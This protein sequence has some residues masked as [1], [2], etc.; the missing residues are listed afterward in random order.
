MP[1]H[2]RQIWRQIWL[3]FR[4]YHIVGGRGTSKSSS[5]ASFMQVMRAETY[6]SRKHLS[7]SASKFRGGKTIMEDAADFMLGRLRDQR[8]AGPYARRL[9]RHAAAVKRE[10]DRWLMPLTTSSW[11]GTV[12][13]GNHESARGLRANW[14]VLDEADNWER[15]VVD[16]YFAP[17][18]A[19]EGSFEETAAESG[20]NV[21]L[22]TG[23]VTYSHKDWAKA[24]DSVEMR[25]QMRYEA[26]MALK[27]GDFETYDRLMNNSDLGLRNLSVGY[28]RWDYT[29]LIIP[30][31]FKHWEVYY[32]AIKRGSR[33]IEVNPKW[34][35]KWDHRDQC[36]YIFTYPFDKESIESGLD[37]GIAD[38]DTWAAENRC[39]IIRANGNVYPPH[40]LEGATETELLED[41]VAAERGWDLEKYGSHKPPLL[42]RCS[43]PCVLGVDPARTSDFASFVVIRIGELGDPNVPYNPLTGEG[44]TPW[45]NVIWAEHHRGMTIRDMCRKI[46]ELKERYNLIVSTP[47]P[48]LA[49]A[50]GIDARGAA[51]GTT[52]RDELASPAPDVDANG[53]PITGWTPPQL[54]YDPTDP[55]YRHLAM[56]TD[57]WPGL[58]LLWTSDSLNTEW[59]SYSK[60]QI[61]QGRLYI[62]RW[63][64]RNDRVD[65]GL[66]LNAGYLG[67]QALKEQLMRVQAEPTRYAMKFSIPGSSKSLRTKD[68]L[69]NAFLYA[70]SA[71]R[72][73]LAL[74]TQ[75]QRAKP[76]AA[77]V[78]VR[79]QRYKLF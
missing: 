13:T 30:L 37:D 14:L 15:A 38:F 54:I 49:Y 60:A 8:P 3:H 52:I 62:A 53:N 51:S 59:V 27:R 47:N 40:I 79:P 50:I 75:K 42:Y 21:I 25:L 73:H 9:L 46:Y 61:E 1:P 69:F 6:P 44:Y 22:Y 68:D 10:S 17:F 28:Q 34:L 18:L 72:A 35:T 48:E 43:T 36:E 67:V 33:E 7:L 41:P 65:Q 12:P 77:G 55:E 63:V 26:Q 76:Q 31:R 64:P 45:N 71:L 24:L 74:L 66:E 57:A 70:C 19:V 5:V 2:Q 16:K 11:V 78:A 58:R 39:Q 29:D 4:Q 20:G 23:T 32:P 56:R